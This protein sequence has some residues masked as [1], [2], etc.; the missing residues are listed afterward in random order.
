M[1]D[2]NGFLDLIL[3]ILT[4]KEYNNLQLYADSSFSPVNNFLM[5]Y[6]LVMKKRMRKILKNF[7]SI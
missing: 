2:F 5:E 6:I 3:L 7:K 1:L 4:V